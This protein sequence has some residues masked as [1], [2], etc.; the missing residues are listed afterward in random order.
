MS[1]FLDSMRA[2]PDLLRASGVVGSIIYVSGFALVQSG[3]TCGNGSLYS[4][5][6]V[7]A[8]IMVLISLVGAFNLGAF[9]IQVGF[10]IFGMV[11]LGR[12]F[13]KMRWRTETPQEYPDQFDKAQ[14][15]RR[16]QSAL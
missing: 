6:K 10:I 1:V 15:T 8:A 2:Y 5:S 9:I 14:F 11:G 3:K 4:A 7:L 16:H 13:L 12:Q